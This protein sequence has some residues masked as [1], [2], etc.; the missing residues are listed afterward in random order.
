MSA[1]NSERKK[2]VNVTAILYL[3]PLTRSVSFRPYLAQACGRPVLAWLAGRILNHGSAQRLIVQYHYEQE[4]APL[5]EALAGT[6]AELHFTRQFTELRAAAE[7]VQQLDGGLVALVRLGC[8]FAPAG[9][10]AR[11]VEHHQCHGNGYTLVENAPDGCGI[12]L[13]DAAELDSLTKLADRFEFSDAENAMRRL[14]LLGE[15]AE[16]KVTIRLRTRAFDFCTAYG[17]DAASLP[18]QVVV[19]LD[20]DFKLVERAAAEATAQTAYEDDTPAILQVLKRLLIE[21]AEEA[22][23]LPPDCVTRPAAVSGERP[24]VLFVTLPSAFSGAE[25]ALCSMIKFLDRERFTPLAVTAREGVFAEKLRSLGVETVCPEWEVL[26]ATLENFVYARQ[27]FQRLRPSLLHLNSGGPL[28]FVAA[29]VAAGVPM[30][31][32][33][34]NANMNGFHDG[35]A[36]ARAAI[37]VSEFLKREALRFPVRAERIRVIYD[38]VDT[39]ALRPE[40]FS[41]SVCR[42]EFGLPPDAGIVLMVARV[43][44]N[45]RYD[46][47]ID[48]AARIVKQV[49]GFQLVFKGDVYGDSMLHFKLQSRIRLLGLEN[50]V[51]WMDFVPDIRRL[52]AAA[53]VLVLCSDREGLG[54]CVVEAMAMELPVVVTD[55]GGTH[56]IVDSGARGGFVVPSGDSEA[57][58]GRVIELLNDEPL[59]RRLG[60]AGREFV[61]AR[62]DARISARAVMEIYGQVLGETTGQ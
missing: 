35:L 8:A 53:D 12:C 44:P 30:V 39:E 52:M 32:H 13:F 48:A 47:M 36:A 1:L 51:R 14:E 29:A 45:K 25:Q 60:S 62:L 3:Q 46:L 22:L 26:D 42:Q 19:F 38:E 24:R 34:R 15:R 28:P 33:V 43:V 56:E 10:L 20:R 31:Q 9:L 21:H 59:R 7:I 23:H 40:E 41:R 18:A 61:R 2:S 58:A 5:E 16:G 57:L 50:V 27:L 6:G 4:R 49:P 55:S 11:M 54:S 17:I 37:A